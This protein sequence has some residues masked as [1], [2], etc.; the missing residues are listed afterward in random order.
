MVSIPSSEA[1]PRFN[2]GD[3]VIA[4]TSFSRDGSAAEYVVAEADEL[5]LKPK[6]LIRQEAAAVPLSVLTAWQA[7]FVHGGLVHDADLSDLSVLVLAAA[8][9]V[10]V[11]AVQLLRCYGVGRVVGTCSGRNVDFAKELGAHGIVDYTKEE[12]RGRFDMVLDCVGG[13]TQDKCWGNVKNGGK[14]VSVATPLSDERKKAFPEV[15]SKFFVVEPDG[16]RLE[17]LGELFE[18][19]NLRSFVDAEFRLEDG[20]AAFEMLAK[21]RTRGKIV[22]TL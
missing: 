8:G 6:A 5:A 19:R 10:G 18:S 1:N 11:M 13:L 12:V 15:H 14:L 7:L 17:K 21:G 20:A 2:A 9:G 4:L 16:E 22:L 3:E